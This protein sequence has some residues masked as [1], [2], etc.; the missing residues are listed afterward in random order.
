VDARW[1]SGDWV[2]DEGESLSQLAGMNEGSLINESVR[3]VP[4]ANADGSNVVDLYLDQEMF[5]G[6][7]AGDVDPETAQVMAV[8]RRPFTEAAFGAPSG[9]I[10]WKSV[11]SRHLRHDRQL[12]RHR[13][14]CCGAVGLRRLRPGRARVRVLRRVLRSGGQRG[15][16][17][18]PHQLRRH[19]HRQRQDDPRARHLDDVLLSGR[20]QPRCGPDR[21]HPGAGGIVMR[22]AGQIVYDVD[23]NVLYTHGPRPQLNGETFCPALAP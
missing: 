15:Q 7:F 2:P 18:G 14:V 8:A 20:Q 3:P 13:G 22:D 23:G 1:L 19:D 11:P 4:Y 10:A 6:A 9:P 12:H 5:P 17:D 16:G 21:P